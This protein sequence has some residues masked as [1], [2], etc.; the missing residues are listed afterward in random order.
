MKNASSERGAKQ[1]GRSREPKTQN[2]AWYSFFKVKFLWCAAYLWTS[3]LFLSFS[4]WRIFTYP[5]RSSLNACPL[6]KWPLFGCSTFY[7]PLL[8]L[9]GRS[10]PKQK[11]KTQHLWAQIYL[12]K[13]NETEY[14][15]M[16]LSLENPRPNIVI[17]RVRLIL[18]HIISS[19][20]SLLPV[21]FVLVWTSE[22]W[23]YQCW[24]LEAQHLPK[25]PTCLTNGWSDWFMPYHHC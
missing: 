6:W 5:W 24:S 21:N 11:C 25:G 22:L 1:G 3:L 15:K 18:C 2:K 9:W 13:D 20:L 23:T 10:S 7:V 14:L 17:I 19:F 4:A 16:A 8:H 12:W